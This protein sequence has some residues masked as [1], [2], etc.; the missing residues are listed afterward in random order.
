LRGSPGP[1][2]C[3]CARWSVGRSGTASTGW[4]ASP[5]SRTATAASDGNFRLIHR[6]FAQIDR[7][8]QI[9]QLR[10]VTEEAVAAARESL[11]I[12]PL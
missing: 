6:L 5:A 2:A 8:M 4:P 3:P 7:L 1:R 9:N 11:V 10:T 12:G